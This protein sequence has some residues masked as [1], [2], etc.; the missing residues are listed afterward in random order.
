MIP[1]KLTLS[2]FTS[3]RKPVVLDF[4]DFNIACISGPNGA[5]KSSI[6]DGMTYALYGKARKSDDSLINSGSDKAE[7]T[8][9]FEYEGQTY[10]VMRTLPRGKTSTLDFFIYNPEP[11]EEDRHWKVLTER[12]ISDTNAKIE[13][14]LRL[15]Y[16]TFVNA[17]FFLQGKADSFATQRPAD[18]KR[19]L[20]SILG[21]NQWDLYLKASKERSSQVRLELERI[22]AR[23]AEIQGELDQE[24]ERKA[25]LESLED[26][27]KLATAETKVLQAQLDTERAKQEKLNEKRQYV[28]LLKQYF[29]RAESHHAD[30]L[31]RRDERQSQLNSFNEI[32]AN[33]AQTEID[34]QTWQE[35]RKAL[36]AFDQVYE[37]FKPMDGQRQ[38]LLKHIE[39][40]KQSLQQTLQHMMDEKRKLDD[41]LKQSLDD[42]KQLDT[43][44]PKVD[45]LQKEIT[46]GE[47]LQEDINQLIGLKSTLE[48]ENKNLRQKMKE[49]KERQDKISA[50][51]G[52]QCP[53]CDQSLSA[54]H[55]QN[56]IDK[57]QLEGTSLGDQFRAN[58]EKTEQAD[59]ALK[60]KTQALQNRNENQKRLQI[61]QR[62]KDRLSQS[63]SQ[64]E[65]QKHAFDSE[66]APKII[67]LETLL[68]TE[69]FLPEER[70]AIQNIE[71]ELATLGYDA[72]AHAAIRQD[73]ARAR[74][75]EKAYHELGKARSSVEQI[76]LNLSELE[77]SLA[78][79]EK[80]R[81]SQEK[82]YTSAAA[83]LAA[84]EAQL[85]DLHQLEDDYMVQKEEEARLLREL[86][87]A[88]QLVD[89][90]DTQRIRQLKLREDQEAL[91]QTL[92]QLRS[93]ETAFGKDGVPAMLIEQALPELE[94]Q[95]NE[96][97]H[98]LSDHTMSVTFST[99]REYK[100]KKR[101]D[102]R[103]TLDILISD[104]SSTRDY[105]TFSG[106]EALRVNFAIRLA[107]SRVLSRR[108]GARMQ[109][110]VIDE[111]FGNQDRHGRQ[112]LI[113]AINMIQ[114]DFE[115]I[116]VITH[117]EELKDQF[118][119]RVEINKDAEGS[120]TLEL[121]LG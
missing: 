61:L 53:F 80:E 112:L 37:Q 120:S 88:R 96:I 6:L 114:D 93:L 1:K 2:G 3:Y 64:V 17:S 65:A 45:S 100:D 77:K 42:Q 109:T 81:Q 43:L 41:V 79:S 95:A 63:L 71:K 83:N 98:K 27:L 87:G 31:V 107:L 26:K 97:L 16:E 19:I 32:L 78:S 57:I 18:R 36:Q 89:N 121:V 23:L 38:D 54:E 51:E 50:V 14:T 21:L 84:E 76:K 33:A 60:D 44:E 66:R 108:A 12:T 90:L 68:K 101:D 113:E 55:R 29:E 106:G 59:L 48:S 72:S 117:I 82:A 69:S 58:Q 56:L 24:E 91:M 52:A 73:E 116:L 85:P 25:R 67:E 47:T 5:G 92:G 39:L 119:N 102:K 94:D 10:R 115:K 46:L 7:V 22:D 13:R 62:E 4:S 105:E 9:D 49:L 35:A 11:E 99:Q 15:D 103:E 110:L 111:G 104:G 28:A 74:L 86:G 8:L 20:A 40:K 30:T 75:A 34:Y 70:M 118:P